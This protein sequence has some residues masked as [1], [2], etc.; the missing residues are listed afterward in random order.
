MWDFT[1]VNT[2]A[3]SHLKETCKQPGAVAKNAEKVK[4]DKYKNLQR[5]YYLVP[6]AVET[7]G[8]WNSAGA[9]LIKTLGK[10]IQEKTGEKRSTF[11]LFQSISMAVQRGNAAS[12]LGTIKNGEKLDEIY[13]L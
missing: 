6:V 4:N 9:T 10:I 13:Y 8:A 3:R 1:C 5:D 7:L 2:I 12:I 11:F